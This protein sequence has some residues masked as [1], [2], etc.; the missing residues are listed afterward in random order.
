MLSPATLWLATLAQASI[1]LP[2]TRVIY[3]ANQ[4][5][6][7]VA[8]SNSANTPY[9][10]QMWADINNAQSTPDTADAPFVIL[11]ALFRVEPQG[12]QAVR[13]IFTGK[14]L[15]QDK[16]S[17]FYLNMVQ[18]PPKNAQWAD[19]N[20]MKIVVRTRIKIFYRPQGLSSQPQDITKQLRFWLKPG[21]DSWQIEASNPSAYYAS[22]SKASM[23]L[24]SKEIPLAVDMLAPGATASWPVSIPAPV[25]ASVKIR[26]T[27]V[28]DYG[29]RT[30][31]EAMAEQQP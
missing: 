26:F 24:D 16:E 14:D 13:I 25:P 27:L 22:L 4:S 5:E 12:G 11:P 6:V 3:A 23:V 1:T 10:V 9:I 30:N 20:Q 28:N 15:P 18:I 29:G 2:N 19:Q 21:T 8:L 7:T 17:V 31:A